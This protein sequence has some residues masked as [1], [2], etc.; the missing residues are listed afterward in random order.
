MR[1]LANRP[2]KKHRFFTWDSLT[3]TI[4]PMENHA[5]STHSD[6]SGSLEQMVGTALR[7]GITQLIMTEH[8]EPSL[9]HGE[10]WF[11]AYMREGETIRETLQAHNLEL[12]MGLEVPITDFSGGLLW[13]EAMKNNAEFVLGAVHAYPGHGWDMRGITPD[14]AIHLEYRGL[15]ALLDNPLVDAIA[16]PG[17]VCTRFVTPFPQ[18]LFED[19]VQRAVTKEMAIELNP[20]YLS[21]MEPYIAMCQ[22]HGVLISPGSNAHTPEEIG[23]AQ[24]VLREAMPHP[25]KKAS[26]RA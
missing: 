19:V 5:H 1:P 22:R 2:R 21:P 23:L 10:G 8:T 4:P 14:E 12:I 25:N 7:R 26:V 24:R 20:A 13:D 17:G 15:L 11:S 18:E 3:T 6:G 9:T 16:H